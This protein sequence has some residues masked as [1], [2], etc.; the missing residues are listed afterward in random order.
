MVRP[1]QN[2][3]ASNALREC[4]LRSRPRT[5]R[6]KGTTFVISERLNKPEYW[7]RPGQ[8]FQKLLFEL[9]RYSSKFSGRVRLPWGIEISVNPHETIGKSLLTHGVYELAVSEFLWRLTD[10]GDHCLDI[11]ANIGYVTSLLAAKAGQSG[12]VSSFEPHPQVFERLTE[13]V[14]S[15]TRGAR[16]GSISPVSSMRLAIGANEGEMDLVE[17]DGFYQN[18]GSASLAYVAHQSTAKGVKHRVKVQC[19]DAL[20]RDA[21]Q[22]GIM[23][24]DVEGGEPAVFRGASGLLGGRKTRDILFEDFQPFPSECVELLRRH[25]YAVF[26][27]GKAIRGPIVWDPSDPHGA[28]RS[29]PWEPVNYL[30]TI[31]PDRAKARLRPRGWLCLRAKG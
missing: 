22:I 3:R 27:V 14:Q 20:F 9:G 18:Q 4:Y 25:G 5:E 24:I 30:A 11:G 17:P 29:V 21:P 13:N 15:W 12:K 23:K 7:F 16:A 19:L 8:L 2:E 28:Y 26:R 31:N 6:R 1:T 10:P